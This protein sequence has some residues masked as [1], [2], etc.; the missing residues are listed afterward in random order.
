MSVSSSRVEKTPSGLAFYGVIDHQTIPVLIRQIPEMKPAETGDT[1]A[2]LDL[3]S[4]G[5]IDSAGLA[6]LIYWGNQ[7][8]KPEQKIILRGASQ[9]V[10]KLI[11]IMRLGKMFE[12][13]V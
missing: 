10:R 1:H 8:L 11:N 2:E 12:L 4:A 5:K 13:R 3:S 7:H 9:Q 6:F